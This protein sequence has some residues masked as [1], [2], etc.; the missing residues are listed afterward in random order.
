MPKRQDD[1]CTEFISIPSR[2][3]SVA[4]WDFGLKHRNLSFLEGFD[5]TYHGY[6]AGTHFDG[7]KEQIESIIKYP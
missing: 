2:R 3:A 7:T 6:I 1:A 4:F 5:P